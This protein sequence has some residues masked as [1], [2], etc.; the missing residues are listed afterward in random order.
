MIY[1]KNFEQKIG[2]DAIRQFLKEHCI[3]NMGVEYV[4]Q[5]QYAVIY[6]DII[7]QL[8]QVHQMQSAILFDEQIPVQDFYDIRPTLSRIRLD[9]TFIEVDELAELRA[10]ISSIIQIFVYFRVKNEEEKYSRIWDLCKDLVLEKELLES[11][12]KIL[13]PKGQ[14]KDNASEELR[15]I[16]REIIKISGE[17]DRKIKKI[18]QGAKKEGLVKEDAEMT[19]RNGRLCIP[20][21]AQFKRKLQ[22]FIHDESATG[23]T[24]FIEPTDVF[25]S[26]NELKDLINAERREIIRILTEISDLIRFSLPNIKIGLDFLGIIDFIRAKAQFAIRIKAGLPHI[27]DGQLLDWDQ[28]IHPLLYL[29]F[30]N[31]HKKV[32]PLNIKL[33]RDSRI[34]IISGPNAGGKSVCLKTIGLVQ[35]MMQSGLLVPMQEISDMGIFSSF[36]INMGDE[37]SIDNDLSTYSSHLSNIKTMIEHIDE[38]SLF[39]IDEFGSGTEPTLG[40]AMA[41]A[42]LDHIYETNCFG[43]ITTHYGNLKVFSESH[44]Q[45]V[46]GAMLFDTNALKPLFILK[47]GK[48][49]SSFT[50]EIARQIGLPES[51]IEDAISKSGTAQIDYERL[52][53]EVEMEKMEWERKLKMVSQTDDK[54]AELID[55][56]GLKFSEFEKQRKDILQ[57]AKNQAI[58]IVESANQVIEKTI[59]DIKEAKAESTKTK[60][61]RNQVQQLKKELEQEISSI[62]KEEI[63]APLVPIKKHTPKQKVEKVEETLIKVGDS[64]YITDI[65]TVGE[66]TKLNGNEVTLSFNSISLKTNINKIVKISK[67]EA[68]N[69]QRTGVSKLD[70]TR[71][72][73]I[74]NEKVSRFNTVID[75]RGKR[76]DESVQLLESFIDETILLNIHQ[77][78]ILHGKGD[79]ILRKVVRQYLSKRKEVL[80]FEDE[81][82]ELGGAGI[83]VI[84]L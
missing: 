83:T 81:M 56:Y 54:L 5:M 13:D 57:K 27:H 84:D 72:G 53:E 62:E 82:L 44:P 35:Y 48:P 79:G 67:K 40:G 61:I 74:M 11:I 8:E 80:H 45:A 38:T 29:N 68:R 6:D 25:D 17:A 63:M 22:G 55:N 39:L 15:R 50:Y 26:N 33:D 77:V 37:Q 7:V 2:F 12:N 10:V 16:R 9:G 32:E 18:L 66:I 3:S 28:A 51:I 41:E 75:L 19:I 71:I 49:G 34:L 30:L 60:E 46:N 23:Q 65:Q 52:V 24:V 59:R 21:P 43:I 4:D 70:G 14:L 78:K 47:Q 64:V 76:A 1:P 69:V 58:A 36:F 20:V 31:S 73:E 42:I